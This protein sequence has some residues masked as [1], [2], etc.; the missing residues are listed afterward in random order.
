MWDYLLKSELIHAPELY[1]VIEARKKDGFPLL[2]QQEQDMNQAKIEFKKAL[3][4]Y[5]DSAHCIVLHLGV[6][7]LCSTKKNAQLAVKDLKKINPNFKTVAI[8]Y[9]GPKVK[10]YNVSIIR[11]VRSYYPKINKEFFAPD[12]WRLYKPNK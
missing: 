7:F 6:A 11:A 5:R 8:S 2:L 9:L 12:Y 10:S 3:N 4:E 1:Y